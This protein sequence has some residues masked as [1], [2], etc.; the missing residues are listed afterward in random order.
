MSPEPPLTRAS[1]DKPTEDLFHD[2]TTR[3][4]R[5]LGPRVKQPAIRRL[6]MLNDA[7]KRVDLRFLPANRL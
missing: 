6:D 4:T 7:E 1:A 5:S 3:R 2:R